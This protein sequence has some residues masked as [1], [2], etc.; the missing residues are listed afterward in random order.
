MKAAARH[1][2]ALRK[3]NNYVIKASWG[4][5]HQMA[6]PHKTAVV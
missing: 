6:K 1:K 4:G 3:L 2:T 5:V